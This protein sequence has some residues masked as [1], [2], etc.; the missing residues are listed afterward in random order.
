MVPSPL[1]TIL[2]SL[3]LTANAGED[4]V[5]VALVD[6]SGGSG[7]VGEHGARDGQPSEE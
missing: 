7:C 1:S 4:V 2:W 6:R 5:E 3:K